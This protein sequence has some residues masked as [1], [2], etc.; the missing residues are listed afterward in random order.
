MPGTG[1]SQRTVYIAGAGIAG[2]TLALTLGKIGL[3]VVVLERAEQIP[4]QGAGLQLGPNAWRLLEALGLGLALRS[5][6]LLPEALDVFAA[7]GR[8][9]V[10]SLDL[11]HVVAERFGA[12]YGVMHRVDLADILF[13]A[14]RRFANIDIILG[15]HGFEAEPH[16]VGVSIRSDAIADTGRSGRGFALVGADGV[17]SVTRQLLL[18]GPAAHY[19]GRLA[20]RALV[21]HE[22]VSGAISDQRTALYL[23]HDVHLVAYPLP[24]HGLVNLVMFR[25]HRAAPTEKVLPQ[26][27]ALPR[28]M[29]PR[30]TELIS[31]AA[32]QWTPWPLYTVTTPRWHHGAIGLIGD[33]AHAMLPFQAQGAAMAIEDAAVLAPLLAKHDSAEDAFAAY[34]AIRQKRVERVARI[35]RT[36]GRI[37]HLPRPLSLGRDLV[38]HLSGPRD[39]L[40]RLDWLYGHDALRSIGQ[41]GV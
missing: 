3:G 14:C 22:S 7:D 29:G 35:S 34:A 37:F 26:A 31:A 24:A 11:G 30:L 20:W 27:P 21:P 28:R 25:P 41:S 9:P 1:T 12:A 5:R 18:N 19:V 40:R 10:V 4:R 33:A 36:N 8:D 6:A 32:G 38:M 23:G 2:L 39:H 16:A 13:D 17:H 15:V